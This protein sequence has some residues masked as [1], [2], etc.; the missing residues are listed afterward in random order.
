MAITR[1]SK[2]LNL[3]SIPST[4]AL[5]SINKRLNDSLSRLGLSK[6]CKPDTLHAI[7]NKDEQGERYHA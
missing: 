4:P 3:G 2:T 6:M 5:D 1:V 7:F